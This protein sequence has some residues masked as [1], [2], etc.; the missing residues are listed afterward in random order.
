MTS[1]CIFK[2][3][4]PTQVLR[5]VRIL[6]KFGLCCTMGG[7]VKISKMQILFILFIFC[8]SYA[9]F[10]MRRFFID[11]SILFPQVRDP[12]NGPIDENERLERGEVIWE[13]KFGSYQQYREAVKRFSLSPGHYIIMPCTYKPHKEA[14]FLLR[15]FTEQPAISGYVYAFFR[16]V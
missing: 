9:T 7:K 2:N 3:G 14:K 13:T 15:I 12:P 1:G 4:A 10:S 6:I 8:P 5:K 16:T 11:V